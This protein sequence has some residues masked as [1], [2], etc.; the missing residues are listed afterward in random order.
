MPIIKCGSCRATLDVPPDK[1]NA[2]AVCPGCGSLVFPPTPIEAVS[3]GGRK[4]ASS[5]TACEIAGATLGIG[6]LFLAGFGY[7]FE[8]GPL[9]VLLPIG[10]LG[11]VGGP[12]LFALG[13]MLRA[14]G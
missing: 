9:W 7:V 10:I 14:W 3:P 1:I 13:R 4:T 11:V 8:D 5:G 6:G 2:T 12:L